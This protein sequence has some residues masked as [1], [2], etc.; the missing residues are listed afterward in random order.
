[1]KYLLNT[2]EIYRV[3]SE[4]EAT[5][6]IEEAKNEKGYILTKYSSQ[7]KEKKQKGEVIDFYWLV[8]LTKEFNKQN[9]PN[10]DIA[11]EYKLNSAF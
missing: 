5:A 7:Y 6:L 10:N 4:D 2:T 8:S 11:V 1:M 3:S 9:E